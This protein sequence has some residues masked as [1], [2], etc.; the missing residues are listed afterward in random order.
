[1]YTSSINHTVRLLTGEEHNY[2]K[3]PNISSLLQLNNLG[4]DS[5]KKLLHQQIESFTKEVTGDSNTVE[6]YYVKDG[7]VKVITM[8]EDTYEQ[9]EYSFPNEL[10]SMTGYEAK[11][12][13]T[14]TLAK[15]EE[16]KKQR[17]IKNLMEDIKQQE[18]SLAE[19]KKRLE[20]LIK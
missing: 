15:V 2:F 14:D 20:E 1:V 6:R 16:E 10:L 11:D 9:V 5:I 12:L 17:Y 8:D 3:I 13:Y 19:S 18:K 7:C 4:S